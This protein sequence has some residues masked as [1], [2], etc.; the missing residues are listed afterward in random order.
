[1][2]SM[3]NNSILIV[4]E[5]Y[6]IFPWCNGNEYGDVDIRSQKEFDSGFHIIRFNCPS[7]SKSNWA[8]FEW[9]KSGLNFY[10]CNRIRTNHCLSL[11]K[12]YLKDVYKAALKASIGHSYSSNYNSNKWCEMFAWYLDKKNIK[13]HGNCSCFNL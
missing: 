9:K 12:Y 8:V 2:V 1:M 5:I 11:G 13:L 6:Y 4:R 10:T 7:E 3:V